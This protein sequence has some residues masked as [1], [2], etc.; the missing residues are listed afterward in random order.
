[1]TKPLK[2]VAANDS[3]GVLVALGDVLSGKTALFVTAPEVNGLMPEVH[4][5][6]DTVADDIALIVE[7]SGSTGAPKRIQ[8]TLKQLTAS[9]TAAGMRLYPEP[10]AGTNQWLLA[11]PT[12]YVAGLNV[13]VRSLF[14]ETQPILMNSGL[15][16]SAEGFARAASLMTAQNRF[17]SLVPAQLNKLAAAA[18]FD[19]FVLSQMR[20]FKAILVGGQAVPTAT[21][22][23]LRELGVSVI[24][25][26]GS[27][28][29]VG[30]CVYDGTPLH[31]VELDLIDG[32]IRI[33]GDLVADGE[34]LSSDLGEFDAEGKLRVLGRADRVV[35]SGGIKVALERVEDLASLVNGVQDCAATAIE[36]AH[37]GQRVAVVYQGSPEVAD[38]IAVQ[39]ADTLGPAGRPV[40][41]VRVDRIPKLSSGKTDLQSVAALFKE[42]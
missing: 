7:S 6:P 35:I 33:R 34:Y 10:T 41:V 39:L 37:W 15:P 25:T 29:T 8:I 42:I 14:A 24:E 1:M 21:L 20:S 19:E 40:R 4:G 18:Q 31:G 16:F 9:A 11:L 36:D 28:E 17:T 5:L 38:S 32:L 23:R 30:G 12:N 26:Y 2:L 22:S 13:L 3:F 27:T